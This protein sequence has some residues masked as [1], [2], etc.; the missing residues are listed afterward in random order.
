MIIRQHNT[1]LGL[2]QML[3]AVTDIDP[4]SANYLRVDGV[5]PQLTAGRNA[6]KLYGNSSLFKT[7]SP[8]LIE[9]LDNVGNTVYQFMPDY[10]DNLKRRTIV[11]QV[12]EYTAAGPGL[13][14]ICG[15]LRDD[16]VP[17]EW[18]DMFNFKWQTQINI[19]PYSSND[20]EI[21]YAEPPT[22]E[23]NTRVK[24]FITASRRNNLEM[25]SYEYGD[26]KFYD[27]NYEDHIGEPDQSSDI[28]QSNK[29]DTLL[30]SYVDPSI[31]AFD[32]DNVFYL[33][34]ENFSARHVVKNYSI[35]HPGDSFYNTLGTNLIRN[36]IISGSG[37]TASYW[38]LS[39]AIDGAGVTA[40]AS[41]NQYKIELA[42]APPAN[43]IRQEIPNLEAGA[44]YLC[45]FVEIDRVNTSLVVELGYDIN[46]NSGSI[47]DRVS[48]LTYPNPTTFADRRHHDVIVRASNAGNNL[49][50]GV[51]AGSGDVVYITNVR[52]YKLSNIAVK[53]FTLN[54]DLVGGRVRIK[55]P[56][57]TP[58][59]DAG[60]VIE[61]GDPEYA[62][63]IDQVFQKRDSGIDDR[64]YYDLITQQEKDNPGES[65]H[66]VKHKINS[67]DS[68]K[69]LDKQIIL[70]DLLYDYFLDASVDTF[71]ISYDCLNPILYG[72]KLY[73]TFAFGGRRASGAIFEYDT[74]TKTFRILNSL[75]RTNFGSNPQG[76]LYPVVDGTTG[77]VTFLGTAAYGGKYNSGS[78][79][80]YT[81]S[82]NAITK[83][84]DFGEYGSLFNIVNR[85]GGVQPGRSLIQASD[86][87]IYGTT[88]YG[89]TFD[90]GVLYRYDLNSGSYTPLVS[91]TASYGNTGL[92]EA[93]GFLYGVEPFGGV[94]NSGSI[95]KYGI[96]SSVFSVVHT[97]SGTDGKQP[98]GTLMVASDGN[99]YATTIS[100][101]VAGEG[102]VLYK[103]D[104]TTDTFTDLVHFDAVTTGSYG[105]AKLFETDG[106]LYGL[107]RNG[108]TYDSGS[109]F[110]YDSASNAVEVIHYFGSGSDGAQPAGSMIRLGNSIYGTTRYGGSLGR[111]TMFRL[112]LIA[113]SAPFVKVEGGTIYHNNS[114]LPTRVP[115]YATLI[116]DYPRWTG[117]IQTGEGGIGVYALVELKMKNLIPVTG[118]VSKIRISAK[119]KGTKTE[120]I[121]LG[122]YSTKP[123][124]VLMDTDYVNHVQYAYSPYRL[125]GYFKPVITDYNESLA[126]NPTIKDSLFLS[127]WASGSVTNSYFTETNFHDNIQII[128]SPAFGKPVGSIARM[129]ITSSLSGNGMAYMI[130]SASILPPSAS[131]LNTWQ[132]ISYELYSAY[133]MLN[134]M[135]IT[136]SNYY[137]ASSATDT[138][139]LN[140]L[141]VYSAL[142][143]KTGSIT[144]DDILDISPAID[145]S[146]FRITGSNPSSS[147]GEH[148]YVFHNKLG[149]KTDDYLIPDVIAASGSTYMGLIFEYN[150]GSMHTLGT[151]IDSNNPHL[152]DVTNVLSREIGDR[153]Y[154]INKYWEWYSRTKEPL[155]VLSCSAAVS[156]D[157]EVLMDSVHLYAVNSEYE[158]ALQ[159]NKLVFQTKDAYEFIA[160][161]PYIISFNA[162]SRIDNLDN[163]GCDVIDPNFSLIASSVVNPVNNIGSASNLYWQALHKEVVFGVSGSWLA[164]QFAAGVFS[165]TLVPPTGSPSAC[166]NT[167]LSS[168]GQ[169]V[170]GAGT[171]TV[172]ITTGEFTYSTLD[173]PT[174]ITVEWPSTG[175]VLHTF[176]DVQPYTTYT[177]DVTLTE[178][179]TNPPAFTIGCTTL[180]N[181][182]WSNGG[183]VVYLLGISV[184][185]KLATLL[186]NQ[187]TLTVYGVNTDY[188]VPFKDV[189]TTADIGEFVG[190]LV[191]KSEY[192][193]PGETKHFGRVEMEFMAE[194]NGMGKI[195][196]ETE[197][198]SHWHLS[199]ISVRPKDRVGLTPGYSRTFIRIPAALVNKPL[200]VKIEYLNDFNIKSPYVT[201]LND[202]IFTNYDDTQ[203]AVNATLPTQTAGG[204]IVP[205]PPTSP[206]ATNRYN[207]TGGSVFAGAI[208]PS[209]TSDSQN[210]FA[211]LTSVTVNN[212]NVTLAA[213]TK[214]VLGAAGTYTISYAFGATGTATLLGG[215]ANASGYVKLN[216]YNSSNTFVSTIDSLPYTAPG[217]STSTSGTV[218]ITANANDYITLLIH[219]QASV[220]PGSGDEADADVTMDSGYI[221][222]TS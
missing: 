7:N 95:Y 214:V 19:V 93:N 20:T 172:T 159:K 150:S 218:T 11:I 75:D 153:E 200:T 134:V 174:Y 43:Y 213:G 64:F 186:P 47:S 207:V 41:P 63:Y 170:Y 181:S 189:I 202:V 112:D 190:E 188:G 194:V 196:F 29:A 61:D 14:T 97:F 80:A 46:K 84:Y 72:S 39:G 197:A 92:V 110:V 175:S 108:G 76:E 177:V 152:I 77:L 10:Y 151:N 131:T 48:V 120:F 58:V 201:L 220:S 65:Y 210:D 82:T 161:T 121:D 70:Y 212:P 105:S 99:I 5:P 17:A 87:L 138:L 86:G 117:P 115:T 31:T 26:Y 208:D 73:G 216:V 160:N 215:S 133:P 165:N 187:T 185:P 34:E 149:W 169:L 25:I 4:A 36:G 12:D 66:I 195:G 173:F 32:R 57:V 171:Y 103:I 78:L 125:T 206:A 146:K 158:G 9:V 74:I 140:S 28:F 90:A 164:T 178:P 1:Y 184:K 132:Q 27:Y 96:T 52:L 217:A 79:Y 135:D 156:S 24:P 88:A 81:L 8:L 163:L 83:L 42:D 203:A 54:S 98:D 180:N 44:F 199:E 124:D 128:G 104:T 205:P 59:I 102:A 191:H 145:F 219:A 114:I 143:T 123:T 147:L 45:R 49:F 126:E 2:D 22:I 89:G 162:A 118:D 211:S 137:T 35:L 101:S 6:I 106:K 109:I 62:S 38:D 182:L 40:A 144:Y 71:P 122:V 193:I 111:G 141:L 3:T 13:I 56:D 192:G 107:C 166:S 221:E 33:R 68:T 85:N 154:M 198:G 60:Y 116:E 179:T 119:A 53:D 167:Y 15:V 155:T 69:I 204:T 94:N 168:S 91:L 209:P 139:G 50:I 148:P 37:Y 16:L 183:M 55:N 136:S 67:F 176:N 127:G 51:Q 157:T 129:K 23:F 30:G 142:F 18:R 21:I 222:V 113:P 130:Y 100:S